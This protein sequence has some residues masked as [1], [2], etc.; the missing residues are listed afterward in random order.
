MLHLVV[1]YALLSGTLSVPVKDPAGCSATQKAG[2]EAGGEK[3]SVSSIVI[4]ALIVLGSMNRL[5]FGT[6][7]APV[8]PSCIAANWRSA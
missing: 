7:R 4:P 3:A 5:E 6:L 2:Q 1:V 8:D